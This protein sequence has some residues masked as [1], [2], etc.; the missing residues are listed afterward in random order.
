MASATDGEY[1]EHELEA[2]V[3]Q[4]LV[5]Y[6]RAQLRGLVQQSRE[7]WEWADQQAQNEPSPGALQKYRTAARRLAEA[8]RA[9]ALAE[10]RAEDF[11][12]ERK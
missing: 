12:A 3:R 9:L 6:D 8:E 2:A 1:A 4:L 11:P 5:A 10:S 7:A